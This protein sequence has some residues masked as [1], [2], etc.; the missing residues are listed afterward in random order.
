VWRRAA[1]AASLVLIGVVAVS[2]SPKLPLFGRLVLCRFEILAKKTVVP[3]VQSSV[4]VATLQDEDDDPTNDFCSQIKIGGV[5]ITF[6]ASDGRGWVSN[7]L[8][9]D[10][11]VIFA[12]LVFT[13][14]DVVIEARRNWKTVVAYKSAG[15]DTE[16]DFGCGGLPGVFI[17]NMNANFFT[18][19][20]GTDS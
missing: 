10:N 16:R 2:A 13:H 12:G 3:V 6:F 18:F 1:W 7:P 17:D 4:L 5:E 8:I 11:F 9:V 14:C 20:D 15:R 19:F